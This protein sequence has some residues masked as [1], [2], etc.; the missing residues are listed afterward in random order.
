MSDAKA[1]KGRAVGA[2]VGAAIGAA[3]GAVIGI[4][5]C[6]SDRGPKPP[7]GAPTPPAPSTSAAVD[8]AAASRFPGAP[9]IMAI[10]DLH[11]DMEATRAALRLAGAIDESDHWSGGKLILVQTGD[12]LDRGDS[13]RAIVELFDRLIE[14]AARA[15]GAVHALNGNHEIMNVAGDFRYVTEGGFKDF[16]NV[17][18]V[19]SLDQRLSRVSPEARARAAAFFPGGPYAKRLAKRNT[20]VIVGDTVF[21][22]GGL[23][24]AHASYGVDRINREVSS[25]M[26]GDSKSPPAIVMAEDAPVWSRLYAD[27]AGSA[28]ACETLEKALTAVRAKRMVIGHTVQKG[29]I[30]SACDGKVWRID[31]GLSSYYGGRVE[32]LE[33]ADTGIRAVKN[34]AS[35]TPA[36]ASSAS[37]APSAS[38][39]P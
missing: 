8:G 13:E 1:A 11:G 9:R 30:N 18:G 20:V 5:A 36:P 10:G 34:G 22:H 24:P 17:S 7:P 31:V 16:A 4:A 38:P 19:T 12:E 39:A 2:V 35:D 6:D 27:G 28:Q 15:G 37:S 29:G 23:L 26:N 14:E 21:V 25:W 3:I 33:I 32:V